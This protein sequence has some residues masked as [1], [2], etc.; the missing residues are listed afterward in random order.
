MA[1]LDESSTP[2]LAV[3]VGLCGHGL[4]I[5]RALHRQGVRVI[6]LEANPEQPGTQTNSATVEWVADIN[7]DALV[8]SLLS[9]A[10]KLGADSG[11]PVLFLTNDRMVAIVARHMATLSQAYKISWQASADDVHRLLGKEAIEAQAIATG[12]NYPKTQVIN[13][14]SELGSV[15]TRLRFPVIFKPSQPISAFKTLVVY[16]LDEARTHSALLQRCLPVLAQEFIAGD[17]RQIHF[18]A[19]MLKDGLATCRFEGRKL[20]SRPMG[21]TTVAVSH[22]DDEVHRLA[23]Q[24]FGPLKMNGPVSLELKRDPNGQYWV[25]E[26]TVGRTDFWLDVCVHN[27]VNLPAAEYALFQPIAGLELAQKDVAVWLNG[28]RDPIAYLWLLFNDTRL[29]LGKRAR[30]LFIDAQDARPAR[31]A[32]RAQIAWELGRVFAKL[33]SLFQPQK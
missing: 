3:I 32:I 20:R 26:P 22:L 8:P 2:P 16:S 7:S 18:G 24:F 23:M 11:K 4:A 15:A 5:S 29:A 21:H 19:L 12:L 25:I 14:L 13:Q 10:Q 33:K 27:G 1:P 17:D 9:L 30:G 31:A 28:Q 6:A